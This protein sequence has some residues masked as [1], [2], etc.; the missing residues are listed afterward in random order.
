MPA[1][2]SRVPV[3]ASILACGLLVSAKVGVGTTAPAAL[4]AGEPV[5][6]VARFSI[7]YRPGRLEMSGTAAS[8]DHERE[9]LRIATTLFAGG[10]VQQRLQPGLLLPP[11]WDATTTRQRRPSLR[12]VSTPAA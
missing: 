12:R 5:T 1:R 7:E 11:G 8:A 10:H 2:N 3:L 6:D 9:L 4:L